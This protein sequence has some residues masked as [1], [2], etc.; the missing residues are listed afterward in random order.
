MIAGKMLESCH[1]VSSSHGPG[2]RGRTIPHAGSLQ[3]YRQP[4]YGIRSHS[5]NGKGYGPP[6]HAARHIAPR[7]RRGLRLRAPPHRLRGTPR[8][9]ICLNGRCGVIPLRPGLSERR[10]LL[11]R[12]HAARTRRERDAL[13]EP[14]GRAREKGEPHWPV[15]RS[16]PMVRER[17]RPITG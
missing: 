11:E 16:R 1:G 14:I 8:G 10:R 6:S 3:N 15:T 4:H 9:D 13:I 5:K 17:E 12:E 2:A 7:L